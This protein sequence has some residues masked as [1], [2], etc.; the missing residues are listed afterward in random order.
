MKPE[1]LAERKLD[2]ELFFITSRSSGP[3]GQNVNKVN[4][5]VELHFNIMKSF[6]LT[7]REK[8]VILEKLWKKINRNGELILTSQTER[9]QSENK[10]KAILKFYL[11][12]SKALTKKVIRIPTKPTPA[13]K[14]KRIEVKKRRSEIKRSRH[15]SESSL[16]L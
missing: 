3:G 7:N 1:T 8:Q 11:I 13:S 10:K 2:E 9:S 15:D 12:L 5:K 6:R 14:E 4:T 16:N